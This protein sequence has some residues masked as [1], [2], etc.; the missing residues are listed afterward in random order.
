M[1]GKED[2]SRGSYFETLRPEPQADLLA[3]NENQVVGFGFFRARIV[4]SPNA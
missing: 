3:N 2:P 4:T 1:P